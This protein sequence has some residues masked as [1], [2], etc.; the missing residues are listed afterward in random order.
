MR[1]LIKIISYIKLKI[2]TSNKET[3]DGYFSVKV[4]KNNSIDISEVIKSFMECDENGFVYVLN[5]ANSI[6]YIK[7][8]EIISVNIDVSVNNSDLFANNNRA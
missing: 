6:T 1:E 5:D 2:T 8:S 4:P 7:M 3:F